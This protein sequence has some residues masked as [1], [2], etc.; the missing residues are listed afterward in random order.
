MENS[1]ITQISSSRIHI[2]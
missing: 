1:N 2:L